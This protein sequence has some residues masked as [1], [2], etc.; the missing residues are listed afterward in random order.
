MKARRESLIKKREKFST[1]QLK[2]SL[3]KP[4]SYKKGII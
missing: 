2:L 1:Q 4:V 3:D